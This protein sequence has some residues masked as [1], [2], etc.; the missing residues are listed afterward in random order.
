MN[1][2]D[3]VAERLFSPESESVSRAPSEAELATSAS[4]GHLRP[5]PPSSV[6]AGGSEEPVQR[7]ASSGP[8]RD[9]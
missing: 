6:P 8:C 7:P 9:T 5:T 1:N 2:T 4:P 3:S